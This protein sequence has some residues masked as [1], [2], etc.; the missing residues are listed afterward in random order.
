[1]KD[2][3]LADRFGTLVNPTTLVIRRWLPGP[4][5]R[6]WSYLTDSDKRR[7]WLASGDMELTPGSPLELVWRNDDL[8]RPGDPRPDNFPA[9]HRLQS[10]VIAADPPHRLVIGWGQGDVTFELQPKDGRVLL[11][12]THTGLTER[13]TKVGVSAGWHVHLDLLVAEASGDTASSFWK[14]WTVLRQTYDERIP[15]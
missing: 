3:E 7:K 14:D 15:Q 5:E 6:I 13:S 12:L 9:E 4:I 10:R 8:S 11:T 1:M 2:L